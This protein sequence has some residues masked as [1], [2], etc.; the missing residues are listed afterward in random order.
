MD[1]SHTT[2]LIRLEAAVLA[3]ALFTVLSILGGATLARLRPGPGRH[4][5]P[6]RLLCLPMRALGV[7]R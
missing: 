4:R 7:A 5:R 6:G 3:L 2:V 1:H